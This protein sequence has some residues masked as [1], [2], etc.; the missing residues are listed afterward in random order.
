MPKGIAVGKGATRFGSVFWRGANSIPWDPGRRP[1][2]AP[3]GKTGQG[4]SGVSR[5]PFKSLFQVFFD[6]EIRT[7]A[8]GDANGNA[9]LVLAVF[10]DDHPCAPTKFPGIGVVYDLSTVR[11]VT[12][13]DRMGLLGRRSQSAE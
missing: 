2:S 3:L 11:Q 8:A 9:V 4:M 6:L 13:P 7:A 12:K 10:A 1:L 5:S